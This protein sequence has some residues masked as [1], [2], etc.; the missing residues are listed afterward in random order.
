MKLKIADIRD[1]GGTQPRARTDLALVAEYAEAM[2]QGAKF[3]PVVVFF[4]GADYW[5]AD[6]FHRRDGALRA[7]LDEIAVEVKQ[8]TQ[9]D[10]VLYSVGANVAHGQRRTNEDKRRAVLRLLEDEEW[11]G[12]S[13]REIARRCAV[14]HAFV[15]SL[16][17][18]SVHDGQIARKVE[19][20]GTV[21]TQDTSNIGKRP[22]PSPASPKP[23][24][25]TNPEPIKPAPSRAP[26]SHIA[27]KRAAAYEA[28][29]TFL[30]SLDA[31]ER[32]EEIA[33]MRTWL[34]TY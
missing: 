21:Y 26:V 30:D 13:D 3:P 5:L 4:D 10:A 28:I 14:G 34:E 2:G 8:G 19:R 25:W 7:G 20:N 9:R 31:E 11:G 32:A 33:A 22:S 23:T 17:P 18:A 29:E 27:A 24:A 15:S 1:D 6:G 12:W 16:R